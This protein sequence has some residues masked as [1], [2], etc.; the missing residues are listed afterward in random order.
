MVKIPETLMKIESRIRYE[1]ILDFILKP[2]RPALPE[3]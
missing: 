2:F 1:N 3:A